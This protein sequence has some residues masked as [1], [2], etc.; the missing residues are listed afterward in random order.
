[1]TASADM[2][3]F[4]P[5]REKTLRA[6]FAERKSPDFKDWEG[7]LR[8]GWY[9][10]YRQ[11]C[12]RVART[13]PIDDELFEALIWPN[14][15]GISLSGRCLMT[16]SLFDTMAS[17]QNFRNAVSAFKA[18]PDQTHYDQVLAMAD[19]FAVAAG[20]TRIHLRINRMAVAFNTDL[21][22]MPDEAALRKTLRW[23]EKW[24]LLDF[25]PTG[26]W[27]SDNRQLTRSVAKAISDDSDYD[28]WVCN[29]FIW[30]LY[31]E[32]AQQDIPPPAPAATPEKQTAAWRTLFAEMRLPKHKDW[33]DGWRDEYR[34]F[35]THTAQ[36]RQIDDSL[37]HD[38]LWKKW[39]G[40]SVVGQSLL[41][42]AMYETLA[43]SQQYRDVL[44]SFK[45]TPDALHFAQLMVLTDQ[46]AAKIGH[47]KFHLRINRIA[48]TFNTELSSIPNEDIF[49]QTLQWLGDFGMLDFEPSGDWFADN[50][51]LTQSITSAISGEPEYDIWYRNMF[52]WWI[53]EIHVAKQPPE[54]EATDMPQ[55]PQQQPQPSTTPAKA[56]R[57]PLNTILYGPPG[58]GK[59]Y[60][61]TFRAV[62][63]LE[64]KSI[65]ELLAEPLAAVH[66]RFLDYRAQGRIAFTTFHQ[67]Y[68]YEDF[69]EGIR[70][71]LDD[72]GG[73]VSYELHDGVFKT[74]CRQ[75]QTPVGEEAGFDTAYSRFVSDISELPEPVEIKTPKGTSFRVSLNSRGNLN[76][77]TGAG[78]K[79]QGTLTKEKLFLK[80]AG[81]KALDYWTG[82]YSGVIQHLQNEYGLAGGAPASHLPPP[83]Q[84]EKPVAATPDTNPPS[85]PGRT[86]ALDALHR[87]NDVV[88]KVSL[89]GSLRDGRPDLENNQRIHNECFSDGN[90]R[91]GWDE[92]GPEPGM[93]TNFHMGGQIVLD[94]FIHKA[95]IG[96]IVIS[97]CTN[98]EIDGIGVITG[99][100]EWTGGS[101]SAG[102]KR[103]DY[104]NRV[105]QVRWVLRNVRINIRDINDG[106]E[107][108]QVTFYQT[109][110]SKADILDL[111]RKAF[112]GS[113]PAPI[114][115]TAM[116]MAPRTVKSPALPFV[117]VIDEIN[118]GNIS[119]IFG[120]LITLIEPTKRLGAAEAKKA[121][122]PYSGDEFGVPPNVY[123]LGTM[124]TADRSIALLDTALRRRFDFVEMMPKPDLLSNLKPDGIDLKQ[125][126]ETINNRIE[127]L[128]DREHTIGHAYFLGDFAAH[129]TLEG[130]A[131]IFRKRIVP[132]LQEYFFEDYA[133]IRLVLGDASIKKNTPE[134][135]FVRE[136]NGQAQEL[137]PGVP[138]DFGGP[139]NADRVLYRI[140]DTAFDK[141]KSYI[142]I[143]T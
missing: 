3:P 134:F 44:T 67:S 33:L 130:L 133:K 62:A 131:A 113:Q 129:P 124:N 117:F 123:I 142:G 101:H 140:N 137:F 63:I 81:A 9:K 36:S 68:S 80:F 91:I 138:D 125:M 40:I 89:G 111:V 94:S 76:L 47:R 46:M 10:A 72:T 139:V 43:A 99:P 23:F 1:M 11:F 97:L 69:I 127:F 114:P 141:A 61:T 136:D 106:K 55:E 28:T 32:Y 51:R 50:L 16:R 95:H 42:H 100:Y 107:L 49:A 109:H 110:I 132:L 52:L 56:V 25:Q 24:S 82:Y 75:A 31:E 122:L 65:K 92:Y 66:K 143:Y 118:R 98:S 4:S 19:A 115:A 64:G 39:N 37:F 73:A 87:A 121:I 102:P 105:R 22:P 128:L 96:D 8:D 45:T 83:A 57:H 74:F 88:W 90:I 41:S 14:Y 93:L 18:T 30:W 103:Y 104:Y 53:Y 21:S 29:I 60:Q 6:L 20:K 13:N 15:N 84:P 116:E 77:H 79:I 7:G 17:S 119:K 2:P 108:S 54:P 48:A 120:E 126:L 38:L 78:R 59:T 71:V 58:T 135:Q 86:L 5:N 34:Q 70:P 27:F 26:N 35:C 12:E 112:S 85:V